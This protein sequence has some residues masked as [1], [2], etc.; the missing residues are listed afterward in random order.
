M[1]N[2]YLEHTMFR[3]DHNFVAGKLI[4]YHPSYNI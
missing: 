3:L 1:Q 2:S 4:L